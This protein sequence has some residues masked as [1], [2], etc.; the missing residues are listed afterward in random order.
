MS[1]Y[2]KITASPEALAEFLGGLPVLSGPWDD[3]FHSQIC[4]GCAAEDCDN[5]RRVERDNPLWWLGL[6]AEGEKVAGVREPTISEIA[7][8]YLSICDED[9][10]GDRSVGIP[11]CPF[12]EE[13]DIGNDGKAIPGGCRLRKY[14]EAEK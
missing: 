14:R 3:A 13:P 8:E 7:R 11:A 4:A 9:C 5:C 1:N 10:G 12:F 2:E 6:P